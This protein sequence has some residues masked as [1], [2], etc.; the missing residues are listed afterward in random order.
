MDEIVNYL[1]SVRREYAGQELTKDSVAENPF[2]QLFSWINDAVNAQVLDPA[3]MIL[4][5]VG[6]DNKPSARTVLIRGQEENGIIFY[7]NYDSKKG[8]DL[9][10]NPYVAITFFWVELDRQILITGRAEK[11]SYEASQKYFSNRPKESQISAIASNQSGIVKN[12]K[13]LEDA[14]AAIEEKYKGVGPLPCPEN[15]GG[16]LVVIDSFEFWQGRP[17]RLHDRIRYTKENNDWKLDRLA[18]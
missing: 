15:W 10:S 8:Q 2:K 16:F 17:S 4:S 6:S 9:V 18:P 12:R 13:S 3:A 7:T 1:N 5:T 14:Y 11:I